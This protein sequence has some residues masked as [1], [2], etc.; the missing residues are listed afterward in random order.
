[1]VLTGEL[2]RIPKIP[3]IQ[4]L[5]LVKFIILHFFLNE[6]KHFFYWSFGDKLYE[7]EYLIMSSY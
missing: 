5:Y 6:E 4:Q 1:M 2:L 3:N 7:N